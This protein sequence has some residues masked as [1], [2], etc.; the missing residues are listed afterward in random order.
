[1]GLLFELM[2]MLQQRLHSDCSESN[3]YNV[4]QEICKLTRA[5]H[6]PNET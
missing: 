1:M 4:N 6:S 3:S 2:K 5:N